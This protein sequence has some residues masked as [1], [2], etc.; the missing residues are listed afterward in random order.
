MNL[1][2]QMSIFNF[3]GEVLALIID[4]FEIFDLNV[5]VV[6]KSNK[7]IARISKKKRKKN[8]FHKA[9]IQKSHKTNAKTEKK[10]CS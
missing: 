4:V 1:D 2:S 8:D 9:Q 3:T 6:T 7:A 10:F 5:F